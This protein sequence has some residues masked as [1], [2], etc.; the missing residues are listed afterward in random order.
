[1]SAAAR[2]KISMTQKKRWAAQKKKAK[3]EIGIP[4]HK[5]PCRRIQVLGV[6][7]RL[8]ELRQRKKILRGFWSCMNGPALRT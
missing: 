8:M 4:L 3:L 5:L 1:M 7:Q 6:D 2:K